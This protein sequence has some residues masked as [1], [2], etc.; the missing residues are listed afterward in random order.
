MRRLRGKITPGVAIRVRLWPVLASLS[1]VAFV[2]LFMSGTDDPFG[3]LGGPTLVS[4]GIMLS[5]SLLAGFAFLGVVCAVATRHSP[6]NRAAWWY[7]ATGSGLHLFVA[8]YLL[9]HG[10]IGLMTWA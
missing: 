3:R 2:L 9:M 10:A 5:W 7:S 4:I 1:V 6:M 8:V